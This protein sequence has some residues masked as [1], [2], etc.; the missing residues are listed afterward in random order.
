MANYSFYLVRKINSNPPDEN[1]YTLQVGD[2][3]FRNHYNGRV[4][5]YRIVA[6]DKDKDKF[7]YDSLRSNEGLSQQ[8]YNIDNFKNECESVV[9]RDIKDLPLMVND[10]SFKDLVQDRMRDG[11]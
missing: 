4:Y 8:L 7:T 1:L 11:Y 5:E 2:F 10:P 3:C 9:K 6:R